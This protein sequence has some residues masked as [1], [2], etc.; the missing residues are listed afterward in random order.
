MEDGHYLGKFS[1]AAH[2]S[3]KEREYWL[4]KLSG[5]LTKTAFPHDYRKKSGECRLE[6]FQF[7]WTG[8]LFL[9]LMKLSNNS[10]QR[11]HMILVAALMALIHRYTF[12]TD[13]I[14]GAPA[15]KQ[16]TDAEFINTVLVLRN[17]FNKQITYKELL[18]Q[19]R[20][21]IIE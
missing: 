6:T 15:L 7:Q 11:L 13:I 9:K 17:T 5:E 3:I 21:T 2:Q 4:N 14:L 16:E 20:N 10:D 12:N 19:V 1:V 18:L 8:D